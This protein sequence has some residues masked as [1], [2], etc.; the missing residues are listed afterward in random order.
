MRTGFEVQLAYEPALLPRQEVE[1]QVKKIGA[2]L[3][4]K[5]NVFFNREKVNKT[6]IQYEPFTVRRRLRGIGQAIVAPN[7][8][9]DPVEIIYEGRPVCNEYYSYIKGILAVNPGAV[10][11]KAPDRRSLVAD[12]KSFTLRQRMN[13]LAKEVMTII[14][15]DY[16]EHIS[17]YKHC[18]KEALHPAQYAKY[19][20][21]GLDTVGLRQNHNA[22]PGQGFCVAELG[23]SHEDIVITEHAKPKAYDRFITYQNP[24]ANQ[25]IKKIKEL[26]RKNK[27][28]YR[29]ES[30]NELAKLQSKVQYHGFTVLVVDELRAEALSW[31]KV[32]HLCTD[33]YQIEEEYAY[34]NIGPRNK[35]ERLLALLAPVEKHYSLPQHT[36]TF[37]NI[38]CVVKTVV[39]G[40]TVNRKV[41]Q[42]YGICYKQNLQTRIVLSRRQLRIRQLPASYHSE[43]GTAK[44]LKALFV[45]MPTI[46]HELA[47]LLHDT[48]DN[49]TEHYKAIETIQHELAIIPFRSLLK[50]V[51]ILWSN[52]PFYCSRP[53]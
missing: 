10:T 48:V 19:L 16:P 22:R 18:I 2:M 50:E 33:A 24:H 1:E 49:T 37:G 4:V 35:R 3:P 9:F 45:M 36:I 51:R 25:E 40:K 12:S 43:L 46:A 30:E 44:D 31:L 41:T 53:L 29:L 13:E 34:R 11:L 52:K 7:K 20:S 21:Y 39:N 15:K 32:P 6:M 23:E 38:K 17:E 47:H 26:V 8:Y 5:T 27:I 28:F 14:V 42:P